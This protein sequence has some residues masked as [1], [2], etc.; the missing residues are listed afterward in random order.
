MWV[1]RERMPNSPYDGEWEG[2]KDFHCLWPGAL[3]VMRFPENHLLALLEE[4]AKLQTPVEGWTAR[5]C[6]SLG[7]AQPARN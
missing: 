3:G 1:A 4:P 7:M 2:G 5:M 6:F